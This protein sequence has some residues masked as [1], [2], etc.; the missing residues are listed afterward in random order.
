MRCLGNFLVARSDTLV[1]NGWKARSKELLAYLV[2]HPDGVSK[3]RIIDTFWPDVKKKSGD[4]LLRD[5]IYHLRKQVAGEGDFKWSESYVTRAG[6]LVA[7]EPGCWW[8]DA[9]TFELLVNKIHELDDKESIATLRRVLDLYR[10]DFCDDTYYAWSESIRERY[11]RLFLD[12]TVKLTELLEV[13]GEAESAVQALDRGIEV[14]PL[15]E[16]LYRRAIKIEASLGR[17][18]AARIRYQKL[19]TVLADEL[20]EDPDP[21]TQ[22]LMRG[23]RNSGR[24]PEPVA[25]QPR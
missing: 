19:T 8:A 15:C 20:G 10:G 22:E 11:R 12:A 2:A 4:H 3:D 24:H 9:W 25:S 6:D 13:Q 5:A 23:F 21:Q 14:D 16:E 1:L 18:N 17:T 7:L